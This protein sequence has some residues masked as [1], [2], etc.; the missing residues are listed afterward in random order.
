[1]A[2]PTSA[3]LTNPCQ[4]SGGLSVC[5]QA[6]Q[7]CSVLRTK[8][9]TFPK[10]TFNPSS[11]LNHLILFAWVWECWG[12]FFFFFFFFPEKEKKA[13]NYVMFGFFHWAK[14]CSTK[15]SL[16]L[17]WFQGI[18]WSFSLKLNLFLSFPPFPPYF[19]LLS[20]YLEI[21]T[22]MQMLQIVCNLLIFV[23]S[24]NMD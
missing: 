23:H 18:C 24:I 14:V 8:A 9:P 21:K 5:P 13:W 3:Q 11:G 6:F 7:E 15:S 20:S 12:H 17:P 10:C 2:G 19:F 22:E 16:K 1:M 4:L